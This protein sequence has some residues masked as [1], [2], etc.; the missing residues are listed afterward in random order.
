[1]ELSAVVRVGAAGQSGSE[2][3]A[4][5]ADNYQVIYQA[6]E[7]C[8]PAKCLGSPSSAEESVSSDSEWRVDNFVSS[9]KGEPPCCSSRIWLEGYR[10]T[11][12]RHRSTPLSESIDSECY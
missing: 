1:M 10:V 11:R 5:D 6:A 12:Q 2:N 4:M 3:S 9:S 7:Y 8:R